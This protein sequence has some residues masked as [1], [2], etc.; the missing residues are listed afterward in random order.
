MGRF[1]NKQTLE[2]SLVYRTRGE[3]GECQLQSQG[4]RLGFPRLRAGVWQQ[5]AAHTCLRPGVCLTPHVLVFSSDQ[6]DPSSLAPT[7]PHN[8]LRFACEIPHRWEQ[9][10]GRV[11]E[12]QDSR[13]GEDSWTWG[14]CYLAC[15]RLWPTSPFRA[16]ATP[17][18]ASGLTR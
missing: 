11:E 12:V 9:V 17:R 8:S 13:R 14:S 15:H 18:G 16:A 3:G 4:P 10:V 7:T 6:K 5:V 1:E 2:L